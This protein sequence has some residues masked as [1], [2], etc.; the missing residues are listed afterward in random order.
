MR[1]F[2]LTASGKVHVEHTAES[3][4]NQKIDLIIAS[5]YL[6]ARE[7]AHIVADT[8]GLPMVSYD[9]RLRELNF[10]SLSGNPSHDYDPYV[11]NTV[12]KMAH[13]L[14]HGESIRDVRERVWHLLDEL[15]R[16]YEGR[17]IL[18]V[19]HDYQSW[20]LEAVA[21]GWSDEDAVQKIG[22]TGRNFLETGEVRKI[23]YR[24]MPRNEHGELDLHRPYVDDVTY[25]CAPPVARARA[26]GKVCEGVM[27]RLPD[28]LDVWYDAGSMPLAQVHYPFENKT[29][30]DTRAEYP[31]DY[32]AEGVDQT[33]GWFY[34][35][36]AV[37]TV[38]GIESPYKNVICAGFVN[39]KNGQK[40]SK[41]RGNIVDPWMIVE[42]Y[43]V[44]ALRWY[45]YAMND[46]GDPKS[47]D[48]GELVKMF[49]KMHLIFYNSLMFWKLYGASGKR[50]KASAARRTV[51]DKWI[52]ARMN[53]TV[54]SVTRSLDAYHIRSATTA[55]ESF[56]D[57]L[58]RWYIRVSRRRFQRPESAADH[59][60][61]SQVLEDVLMTMTKLMAPFMPFFAEAC[62]HE[63]RSAEDPESVHLAAWPRVSAVQLRGPQAADK[64]LF[65]DMQLIRDVAAQVLAKRAEAGIKVRQPLA[66]L[67]V[68][69][70]NV[71][72]HKELVALLQ[73]EVNVKTVLAKPSLQEPLVLDTALTPELREEGMLREFLRAVQELRQKARLDPRD[74][75]ELYVTAPEAVM[76]MV[77]K[78]EKQ[79]KKDSRATEVRQKRVATTAAEEAL[80][81]E[82]HKVWMGLGKARKEHL[83]DV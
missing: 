44:D 7:T 27:R 73:A 50:V 60:V 6:R 16:T 79:I 23:S 61:A 68:K 72:K 52:L 20:M 17:R 19:S 59:A 71:L 39:D 2:H 51:L 74:A 54:G 36:M 31:A 62:Y 14:P 30:I 35:L 65:A 26:R 66:S 63:L 67:T 11:P 32:I 33:R 28:V 75:I 81:L 57:D 47:F 55:L 82:R 29:G 70:K 34:T 9:H 3:L 10:G 4:K 76:A 15:E 1:E 80:T 37:A 56:L 64:K 58:S 24:P 69:N 22:P 83:L 46:V 45:F 8:I 21:E 53:E 38:L 48:E 40:M 78:H 41:S 18:L 12:E 77:R 25:L 49:R 13:R 5:D 43:G 42:K